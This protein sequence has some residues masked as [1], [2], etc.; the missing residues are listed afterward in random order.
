MCVC[1]CVCVCIKLNHF[2]IH[3]KHSIVNQLYFNKKNNKLERKVSNREKESS[4]FPMS[5][6]FLKELT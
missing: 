5:D 6:F 1:V 4:Q 2:A 3:L